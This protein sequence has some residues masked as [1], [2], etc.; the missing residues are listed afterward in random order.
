[1][2]KY[3]IVIF[4]TVLILISW[5]PITRFI[6]KYLKKTGREVD[7]RSF[8]LIIFLSMLVMLAL[9]YTYLNTGGTFIWR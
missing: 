9:I 1:M 4:V 7:R 6:L 2:D 3:L 8:Y 5:I